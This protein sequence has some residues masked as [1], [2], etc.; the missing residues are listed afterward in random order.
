FISISIHTPLLSLNHFNPNHTTSNPAC[1]KIL[2]PFPKKNSQPLPTHLTLTSH[3]TNCTRKKQL[4]YILLIIFYI[5]RRLRHRSSKQHH[6]S[7]PSASS[8]RIQEDLVQ[9][10][11]SV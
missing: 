9:R 2:F 4:Q 5:V 11:G 1:S 6:G 3:H 8:G 7:K 10:I